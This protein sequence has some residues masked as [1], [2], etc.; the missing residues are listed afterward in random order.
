VSRTSKPFAQYSTAL[1]DGRTAVEVTI[2]DPFLV[3]VVLVAASKRDALERVR[4]L[5][6]ANVHVSKMFHPRHAAVQALL[7]GEHEGVFAPEPLDGTWLPL[8]ELAAFLDGTSG[9]LARYDTRGFD[10]R[11]A[12]RAP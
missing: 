6:G 11:Y 4:G 5:G 8:S 10:R 12:E 2:F 3:T 9:Q 7:R 1:P